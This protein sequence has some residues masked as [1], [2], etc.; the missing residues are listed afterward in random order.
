V[1]KVCLGTPPC[2]LGG[3]FIAPRD[4]GAIGAS[5]GSSQSS[6]SAGAPYYL[7]AHRIVH[8]T[9]V[10]ISLICYFPFQMS[11]RLSGGGTGQSGAPSDRWLLDNVV[12]SRWLFSHLTVRHPAQTVQ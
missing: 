12:D 2:R 6:L 11:T 4:L 3:P 1:L 10:K 5:F 8:N 9:R 7:V